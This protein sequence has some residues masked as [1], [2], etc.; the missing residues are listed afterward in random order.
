MGEVKLINIHKR[1]AE[2]TP[3]RSENKTM[4]QG[5]VL[6]APATAHAMF[7]SGTLDA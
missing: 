1:T 6:G 2:V 5:T 7:C 3:V 4:S